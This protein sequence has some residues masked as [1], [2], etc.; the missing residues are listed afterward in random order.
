LLP[1]PAEKSGTNVAT[2]A[3]KAKERRIVNRAYS[4]KGGA[5]ESATFHLRRR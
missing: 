5:I 3:R 4:M 2:K 1:Q